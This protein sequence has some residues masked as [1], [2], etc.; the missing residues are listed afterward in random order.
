MSYSTLS[1]STGNLISLNALHVTLPLLV[2]PP[3]QGQAAGNQCLNTKQMNGNTLTESRQVWALEASRMS[4]SPSQQTAAA[5]P[6]AHGSEKCRLL[7][8]VHLCV[9]YG[10]SK[11]SLSAATEV[12][13]VKGFLLN[14]QDDRKGSHYRNRKM[15]T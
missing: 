14:C 7:T 13:T 1:K 6:A 4:S 10:K 9:K 2:E 12:T 11:N 5:Q 3:V 8:H 15:S